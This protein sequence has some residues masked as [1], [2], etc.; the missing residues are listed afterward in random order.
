ML[1][2]AALGSRRQT[3]RVPLPGLGSVQRLARTLSRGTDLAPQR[4]GR[5]V[6]LDGGHGL[7]EVRGLAD[8]DGDRKALAETVQK[9]LRAVR[10][11]RWSQVNAVTGHALIAFDEGSLDV[12]ELLEAVESA[13]EEHGTSDAGWSRGAPP[14]P[15]DPTAL[16]GAVAAL[17]ADC[18]GLGAAV[19]T[20]LLRF[21]APPSLRALVGVVEAQPRVRRLAEQVLG[22]AGADLAVGIGSGILNGLTEGVGPL[23][24]TTLSH[25]QLVAEVRSRQAVW[26]EQET[27]LCAAPGCLPDRPPVKA[28]RS[29]P[30]PSGP[31][32]AFADR[33][34]VVSG[35]GAAVVLGLTGDVNRAAGILLIG[36]P[37]AARLGREAFA[38]TLARGLSGRHV[39]PMDPGAFRRLDRVTVVVL[40]QDGSGLEVRAVTG[41]DVAAR[42][43]ESAAQAVRRL[44]AEGHGVLLVADRDNDALM[45][46]DVAVGVHRDGAGVAWAADLI[47]GPE[48]VQPLLAAVPVA[49]RVSRR[50][51]TLAGLGSA[52]AGLLTAL[53]PWPFSDL[54][55]QP[56]YVSGVLTQLDGALAARRVLRDSPTA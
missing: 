6:A 19:V 54:T 23:V 27:A 34:A 1:G 36:V 46:A 11:V 38:A 29:A 41:D 7:I 17:A 44:Q 18:A 14:H 15:A 21:P 3:G 24:V 45:A 2:R 40:D 39:V 55:L 25:A 47:C 26:R 22:Q 5:H 56:V 12:G 20:A 42:D 43:G 30:F 9:A 50:A 37:P 49:R 10:G 51:V 8:G 13:E 35:L 16:R 33:I 48:P 32:E 31:V 4:H 52:A 53:A 28:A